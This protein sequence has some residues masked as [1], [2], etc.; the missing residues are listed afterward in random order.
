MTNRA[1]LLVSSLALVCACGD[2]QTPAPKTPGVANTVEGQSKPPPSQLGHYASPDG[3][4][5]IVVDRTGDAP[6]MQVDKTPGVLEL[7][8]EDAKDRGN[9]VGT[10]MNGPDGRHWLFL[11]KDGGLWFI[12][13][14]ARARV[15]VSNVQSAGTAL[16]RDADAE[17]LAAASQ[18]GA[19]TPPTEKTPY[20]KAQEKLNAIAVMTKFAQFKPEDSGNLSRV[21]QAINAVDA[22]MLVRVSAKGAERAR[23][24]PASEFIG[25]VQQG[26]G[27][28][29]GGFPADEP[30][31]KNAK[32]VAKFGGI[33]KGRVAFGDPS[34]LRLH[35]LKG[36]PPPLAAG[37]P[38]M[39]W[40]VSSSTVVFVSFDGGRYDLELPNEPDKDGMPVEMGAGSVASWPAPIQHA[41]LDVDSIRGLA[42]GGAISEKAGKDI[43][44]L[45]DGWFD[46]VNKVWADGRKEQ[47][48]VEAGQGGADA[49]YG[50]MSGVAKSYEAKAVKDCDGAK[51]K[52]EQ[53]L[54]QFIE[55]RIKDRAALFD[56]AKARAAQLGAK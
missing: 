26:L 27:G 50:R 55:A 2:Q 1:I 39:V 40:M 16:H 9:T 8:M 17:R 34:R 47:Q 23:W 49:K 5:G 4:V 13:P 46:C 6:K 54:A 19:P 32:S 33:L 43:E 10:W 38:G 21:E 35:Q 37:T 25:N 22:S 3:M 31:D 48:K 11:S 20:D 51:K 52:L 18:K 42:K 44:A 45:D 53:G 15:T 12:S 14:E 56:K 7:L 36:W 30:W 28:P 24:A 29:I 41:F